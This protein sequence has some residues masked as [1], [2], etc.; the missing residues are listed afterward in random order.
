MTTETDMLLW[1]VPPIAVGD[2]ITIK[3]VDVDAADVPGSMNTV[4]PRE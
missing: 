4:P 2:E 1:P 3:I